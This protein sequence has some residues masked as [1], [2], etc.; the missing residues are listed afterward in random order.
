[1]LYLIS[2]TSRS[3]KTLMARKLMAQENLPYLSLDWLIMGFTNGVPEYGIHDKLFPDEI[4]K[5]FWS[6]F[7]AMC[8]SMIWTGDDCVIEGE[9]ILPEL[10]DELLKEFPDQIRIV[11]VGYTDVDIDQKVRDVK[12]FS[13]GENDWLTKESDEYII[14]HIGNMVAHSIKIKEGCETYKLPYF[15]TSENFS[16]AIDEAMSC[17]LGNDRL[18]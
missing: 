2:G 11:F 7:R 5:R 3:G 14:D 17:L 1:M 16:G 12:R 9:A 8:V 15:D 10:I 6:F 18:Q 4:A 13:E